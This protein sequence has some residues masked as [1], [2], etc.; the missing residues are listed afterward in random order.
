M[1]E[2]MMKT[3]GAEIEEPRTI[4]TITA[5]I[6]MIKKTANQIALHIAIELGRRLT[7]AKE[8]LP[9]GEWGGWLE[10]SV[11]FSQ[12]T[13]GRYMRLYAE[14]GAAQSSLFGAEVES[15]TLRNLSVSK[16]LAL[17]AVPAEER[18]AFAEE[19]KVDELSTRQMNELMK[20]VKEA[21]DAKEAAEAALAGERLEKEKAAAE[22]DG[23]A[24][25]VKELESRPVEVAVREPDP[26]EVQARVDAAVK[27]ATEKLKAESKDLRRDLKVARDNAKALAMQIE[28]NKQSVKDAAAASAERDKLKE[29]I[30]QLEKKL[31]MSDAAVT[32]VNVHYEAVQREFGQLASGLTAIENTEVRQKVRGAVLALLDKLRAEAARWQ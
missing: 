13:A 23:L 28:D 11:Q 16:A 26:A 14:Y 17:L 20:S 7:E 5:E 2:E 6:V 27:E 29:Q 32:A 10:K 3:V 9:Y 31:S 8:L 15:A 25:R 4:E 21:E 12:D 24:Q 30:V 1:T 22:R 18:E 19:H